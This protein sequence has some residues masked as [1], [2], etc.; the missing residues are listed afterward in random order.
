MLQRELGQKWMNK[1]ANEPMLAI[2]FVATKLPAQLQYYSKLQEMVWAMLE[3]GF[4]SKIV[5]PGVT[6]TEVH[7]SPSCIHS[8]ADRF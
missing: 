1:T 5:A 7:I 8:P 2:E 6:T 3:E 4:S